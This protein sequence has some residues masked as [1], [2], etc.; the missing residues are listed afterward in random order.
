MRLHALLLG[1]V[2]LAAAPLSAQIYSANPVPGGAGWV[3][4]D[5]L[6][7]RVSSFQLADVDMARA[8][9]VFD[10][11]GIPSG[12]TLQSGTLEWFFVHSPS[13][14]NLHAYGSDPAELLVDDDGIAKLNALGTGSLLQSAGPH[15]A[16]LELS[17]SQAA[18]DY[19]AAALNNSPPYAAF[20]ITA[21]F[22]EFFAPITLTLNW[23]APPVVEASGG[24]AGAGAAAAAAAANQRQ[25]AHRQM[26]AQQAAARRVA[27]QQRAAQHRRNQQR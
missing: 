16:P 2:A 25:I 21:H 13:Y 26:Q 23:L 22:A 6:I 5:G 1:G 27:A 19:L 3:W 14:F 12:A 8:F 17:L 11:D 18:L 24:G 20:G 10:L 4:F 15:S 9:Y 7:D